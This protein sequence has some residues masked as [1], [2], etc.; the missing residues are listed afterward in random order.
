MTRAPF[1]ERLEGEVLAKGAALCVGLDPD[2][3]KIPSGLGQGIEAIRR[4]TLAIIDATA[5]YAVAFKPN[6]A[7][8]ERLGA[9]GFELLIE[10]V[11]VAGSHAL[12]IADGKRGDIGSTSVAYAEAI[13]DVI[14][15]DACT[16]S[17]YL[18]HDSVRPFLDRP[19][20]F[21]FILCRTSNPGASD[22]QDLVVQDGG[23]PLYLH[24]AL[25]AAEW[26]SEGTV[27]LVAGATWP[28]EIS[29]I[30]EAAPELPILLPGVGAQGAD[31]IAAVHAAQGNDG[32]GQYLV[33]SSRAISQ[34]SGG[35]DFADAAA[36]AA[37][38]LSDQIRGAASTGSESG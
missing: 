26:N 12:V 7:F 30:R 16:V 29:R 23:R 14:G 21:A 36:E 22:F 4:H 6:L 11:K 25:R 35:A 3:E 32:R 8:F 24:M 5:P 33:S 31:V 15:A 27:G 19:G 38:A 37:R 17:G 20:R 2:P 13:F 28:S 9:P 1:R 34:A 18:G 10:V